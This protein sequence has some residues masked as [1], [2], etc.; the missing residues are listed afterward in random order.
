MLER[1]GDI[2]WDEFGCQI[3]FPKV[4]HDLASPDQERRLKAQ[5]VLILDEWPWEAYAAMLPFLIELVGSPKVMDRDEL[6]TLL[7]APAAYFPDE[8]V[9]ATFPKG[10]PPPLIKEIHDAFEVGL[11]VYIQCL[12]DPDPRVRVAA[13][14][15][16]GVSVDREI[17]QQALLSQLEKEDDPVVASTPRQN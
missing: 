6:L 7:I 9:K 3:D 15:T 16:L 14:E 10:V 2:S 1:V 5:H 8:D 17:V 4:L 12:S 11:P 13:A